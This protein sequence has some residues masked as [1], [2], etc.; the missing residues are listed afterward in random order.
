MLLLIA[1]ILISG[2]IPERA[3]DELATNIARDGFSCEH[4][5]Q[6]SGLEHGELEALQNDLL[7]QLGESELLRLVNE[8]ASCSDTAGVVLPTDGVS[9]ITASWAGEVIEA[10]SGNLPFAPTFYRRDNASPPLP[11]QCDP[12]G[13]YDTVQ[14]FIVRFQIPNA[15][16]NRSK[17]KIYG[18][19]ASSAFALLLSGSALSARVYSDNDVEVCAPGLRFSFIGLVADLRMIRLP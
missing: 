14:D 18:S 10:Q 6:L 2:C 9:S 8:A 17:L 4:Q 7:E 11:R 1:S 5:S 16:A 15:F 3:K 19:T 12:P 13:V